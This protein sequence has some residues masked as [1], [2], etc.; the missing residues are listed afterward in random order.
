MKVRDFVF[1]LW[2]LL[3]VW[4]L[5][6]NKV[7]TLLEKLWF[8]AMSCSTCICIPSICFLLHI[9]DL[10]T[11]SR[12]DIILLNLFSCSITT[13]AWVA[14]IRNADMVMKSSWSSCGFCRNIE[15]KLSLWDGFSSK[16]LKLLK[17]CW[18]SASM[19][20]RWWNLRKK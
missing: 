7:M 6:S 12:L 13:F 8:N 4:W 2:I 14:M 16:I 1:E 20:G 15:L 3:Q 9:R 19:F 18:S 10:F 17:G 11:D 5:F